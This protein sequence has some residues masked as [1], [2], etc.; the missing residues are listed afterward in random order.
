MSMGELNL[1]KDLI[2]PEKKRRIVYRFM[3]LYLLAA[4]IFL[5]LVFRRAVKTVMEGVELRRETQAIHSRFKQQHPGQA[6]LFVCANSLRDT[7]QEN[8]KKAAAISQ[9][10]PPATHSVIP[11]L[12]LL[13][14]R[15]DGSVLNKLLFLQQDKSGKPDFEFSVIL[16]VQSGQ[17]TPT[18][19]R[20]WRSDPRLARQ[21]N[22]I[23]PVTTQRGTVDQKEVRIMQYKAELRGP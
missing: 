18:F 11:L 8:S 16:P 4:V 3:L 19:L 9:A 6:G 5:P 14:S 13:L 2:W 17:D 23:V 20:S 12:D 10:L 21:F 1:A 22:A 15:H 7:L